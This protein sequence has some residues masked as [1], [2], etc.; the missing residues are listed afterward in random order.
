MLS[1]IGRVSEKTI[2][3]NEKMILNLFVWQANK[4][5]IKHLKNMEK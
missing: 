2:L 5:D 4:H 1:S 3:V